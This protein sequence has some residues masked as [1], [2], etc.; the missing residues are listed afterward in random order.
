MKFS[1]LILFSI[2]ALFCDAQEGLRFSS[3]KQFYLKGNS[4]LIGNNIVSTDATEPHNDDEIINDLLKLE[5]IDIDNDASTFSSSQ[6]NLTVS[7]TSKKIKYAAL[8]WSAVYK[9]D[10]GIRKVINRE[11]LVYKGNDE[12]SKNINSI[13]LKLPQ[14]DYQPINGTIIY[15]SFNTELF[16]DTK[17]YVCYANITSLLQNSKTINGN[18]TVANIRATE[19]FVS[20]GAAGGWLLYVIY[21]S[22]NE[23][24]KYFT[25]YNGFVGVDKTAT[26]IEFTNFKTNEVGKIKTSLLLGVLE[27]DQKYKTDHC[28]ILNADT[29]NYTPLT[30]KNR[31]YNNFFNS[32]I[33]MEDDIFMDRVPNST[34]TLGFDLLKMSI[35]NTN[36]SVLSNNSSH[37]TI[38]F[39]TKADGFYL[40][41][42]A[43]ETEISPIYLEEKSNEDTLAVFD[44][45]D[46]TDIE[47]ESVSKTETS[48][49]TRDTPKAKPKKKSGLEKI[50]SIKSISIPN[51]PK[52]YYLVT[53]VFSVKENAIKWMA[54]LEE[55]GHHPKSY[56]NPK[57]GWHYIYLETN[58]DAETIYLKQKELSK[59][60]YFES[61]WILK[62]N[63]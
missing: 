9:Y 40:F 57:N 24:P 63:F 37:T 6:A 59:L 32:T 62:I 18:Y 31:L 50:K 10:K 58:E 44:K 53:N 4:V 34:N 14:G 15:D 54:H 47:G 5:Y 25:T 17:P 61:I 23:T 41:F 42:V 33:T 36:N 29:I 49:E 48:E 56:V 30:T 13:L 21:E 26:D 12:R 11:K 46:A 22:E 60:K 16:E 1:F 52:G 20:G 39:K 38:R 19:G 7:D 27:G 2:Y 3:N 51:I 43:F 28:S 45:N 55:K 35:P 8:Y